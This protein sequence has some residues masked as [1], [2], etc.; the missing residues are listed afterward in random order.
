MN[1]HTSVNRLPL[2]I[3]ICLVALAGIGFASER[4]KIESEADRISYSLGYQMGMDFK[5]QG[6]ALDALAMEQ[7]IRDALAGT[8]PL[9]ADR[10]MRAMLGNLKRRVAAAQ[11]EDALKRFQRMKKEAE[12]KRRKGRAFL[13]ANA[14]KTGVKTLPSRLQYKVIR[15]GAGVKPG[16]RDTVTVQYRGML[17]DGREFD[18]SY[19][20]NEPA[21]FRVDGVIP[22]WAEALQL[23]HEGAKWELYIPPDLAYGARGPVADE[24]LIFEVELL[25]VGEKDAASEGKPSPWQSSMGISFGHVQQHTD[26]AAMEGK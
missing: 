20:R 13:E 1:D 26:G 10:E 19:R 17:I 14:E 15:Q 6:L 9:L 25:A 8:G 23:M 2:N 11:R 7:G 16:P 22:G 21:T 5:R 24:T 3:I 12:E 4:T 18:S